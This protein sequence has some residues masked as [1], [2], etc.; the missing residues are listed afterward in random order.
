MYAVRKGLATTQSRERTE[1]GK[2]E[3][4]RCELECRLQT[5]EGQLRWLG[6]SDILILTGT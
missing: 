1:R 6:V 4:T 5:E 3:N 2:D